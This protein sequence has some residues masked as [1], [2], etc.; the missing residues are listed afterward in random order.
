MTDVHATRFLLWMAERERQGVQ[1]TRFGE[2]AETDGTL[3]ADEVRAIAR[4]HVADGY[5][6]LGDPMLGEREPSSAILTDRGADEARRIR[7]RSHDKRARALASR[8]AV[9][10]WL[11]EVKDGPPPTDATDVR[12]QP[13]SFFEGDPFTDEELNTA[14]RYLL[15]RGLIRGFTS[16]GAV[17][18]A[19]PHITNDGIDCVEQNYDGSVSAYIQRQQRGSGVTFHNYGDN[20]GQQASGE[21]VNQQQNTS[22]TAPLLDLIGNLMTRL[23]TLESP[24]T[25][26]MRSLVEVIEGEVTSANPDAK[27]VK[28]TGER[29]KELAGKAGNSAVAPLVA[30]AVTA[31]LDFVARLT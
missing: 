26:R 19:R 25:A 22:D 15:D 13:W 31:A 18:P 10:A 17:G 9:L 14:A 30:A 2:F 29:L 20:Y 12:G 7:Q 28:S 3:D 21:T 5:I 24:D 6:R 4:R 16:W 11:Y 23:N 8:D 1:I 27:R